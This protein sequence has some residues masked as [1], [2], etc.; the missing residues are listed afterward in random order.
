M[1]TNITLFCLFAACCAYAQT[2]NEKIAKE[3]AFEKK[4]SANTLIISN[5]NGNIN[6]TGY[7]GDKIIVEAE[8]TINGKTSA[9]LEKG[10]TE[11]QLNV[12]DQADTLVVY[13]K[14]GCNSYGRRERNNSDGNNQPWG[15]NWNCSNNCNIDYDYTMHLTIKVPSNVNIVAS[16]I[17]EGDVTIAGMSA[18]VKANN[19]NGSIKLSNLKSETVASTI[20]GD[21]DIEYAAN[22]MND[23]RFY[24]LNGDINAIFQKGLAAEMSFESFN[25]NFYTNIE[26]ILQLPA[27]VE[28]AEQ[29]EGIKFK[30]QGNHYQIGSGGSTYLD[31]ETFNGNVYLKEKE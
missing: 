16:T 8:K 3:L 28:K 1:K 2:F 17:N 23:C 31:F 19:I 27:R 6:I 9:R 18:G 7:D 25:G 20:N 4:S 5:I 10:K 26:K 24:S 12:I 21:V 11:V 22:P 14:D 30:V 15:Y 13:V 29:S